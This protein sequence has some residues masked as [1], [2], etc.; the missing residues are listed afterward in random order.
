M[1][2]KLGTLG[3]TKMNERI[4]IIVSLSA[5]AILRSM[6]FEILKHDGFTYDENEIIERLYYGLEGADQIILHIE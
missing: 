2:M 4:E 5:N 1:H 3:E 6:L